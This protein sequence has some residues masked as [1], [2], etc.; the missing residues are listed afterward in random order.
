MPP[1]VEN[2]EGEPRG[3]HNLAAVV[4]VS[5]AGRRRWRRKRGKGR[6]MR[7]VREREEKG[8]GTHRRRSLRI[9]AAAGVLALRSRLAKRGGG[10]D[11]GKAMGGVNG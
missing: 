3:K 1:E 11:V 9:D 8:G 2:K 5:T 7:R 4:F 10:G 6:E